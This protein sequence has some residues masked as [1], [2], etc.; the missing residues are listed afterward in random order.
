MK[1]TLLLILFSLMVGTGAAQGVADAVRDYFSSYTLAGYAP[2]DAMRADSCRIDESGKTVTV[3][4]NEAFCAQPFTP[5]LVSTICRDLSRR[6]PPPY[7]TYRLTVRDRKGQAIEELVPNIYRQGGEDRSRLWGDI[8]Y[9]GNAWVENTSRP[10][11]INHGLAGRHLMV[12]ASHGRYYRNGRWEWQRPYIFCTTEDLFTQSYVFPFLIPMLENAGAVVCSARERDVQTAEAVVDNDANGRQGT[13][14]ELDQADAAWQRVPDSCGFA[15]PAGLLTDS[16]QPFLTGTARQVTATTR[17]SR[18]A[19]ATWTPR[20]PREGRYAVYVSYATRPNSVPDAHYTVYHKGGRTQF[21]VNQQMGGGTWVYLGTFEFGVGESRENRVVLTNQSDFRGVVTADGVR[22]GG[23][24]G[25][26]ARGHAG[27]SGLPRFLEGARYNAQWA[28]LPDT[29]FNRGDGTNDYDDD[30]RSRSYL[31]NYLGG[32]SPYMPGLPGRGV[33]FELALAVHSDAGVRLDNSIYGTLGICTTVDGLGN[34]NYVAGISRKASS[35]FTAMLLSTVTADLS[36]TFGTAWT[37]RELWDRNYGET[38]TPDV[39]SAILEMLSH[40]N[41]ADMAYGHD[42]RFKFTLSRAVYKAILHFVNYEHGI[43]DYEVQP[44][45]VRAFAAR[46]T[47]EGRVSLSWQAVIDSLSPGGARPTGYVVYTKLDDEDFDNG[48]LVNTTSLTLPVMADHRYSFRVTAVNGGGESFPS[49]VLS[50]RRAARTVATILIVNGFERLGGPA[51]IQ[52]ADSLGFDLDTDLGVPYLYT[53]AYA[54][55]QINFSAADAGQE[56]TGGLGY[57]GGELVGRQIAGNTF[58]YPVLHGRAIAAAG[59]YSF[60][61]CS[62]AAFLAGDINAADYDMVDYIC[63]L[64]CHAPQDLVDGKTFDAPTRRLLTGY[65]HSGGRLFVSGSYIGSDMATAEERGFTSDILKYTCVGT[66]RA[67][68]T[69]R[70]NGLNLDIPIRRAVSAEGYSLQAPDA[71][72]PT[73]SKAFTAFAYGGGRSAGIAYAGK[74]YRVVATGFPF[75]SITD[76]AVRS[77]AIGA[78]VRFLTE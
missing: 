8:G 31:L 28:G 64:E 40:Q 71:I 59:R 27:T 49:E 35:D 58:D 3:F 32:G 7:N 57:C 74:D 18:L 20:L 46:L 13:Y 52:T 30:I 75:E 2:R 68:S 22:F 41:F 5:A 54:G 55:R 11:R 21:R 62:K 69:G 50:V 12:N 48:Q 34:P 56:G 65:L 9:T 1:K 14:A 66:A 38:R 44:L 73:D 47:P 19:T 70:V 15:P 78:I 4:A 61:S 60:V 51:R 33:P 45:P 23:G 36:R 42:P 24:V 6:L 72:V 16:I 39:P 37:R 76:A 26:T 43:S 17:R 10:F 67:D 53:T 77:K 63:G 25:Q 29:L